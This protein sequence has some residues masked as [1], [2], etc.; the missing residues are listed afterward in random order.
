[1]IGE[2]CSAIPELCMQILQQCWHDTSL[3]SLALSLL[4]R[5]FS[6]T[7]PDKTR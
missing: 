2:T 1:M 6:P 4:F 7:P 5:G 3:F